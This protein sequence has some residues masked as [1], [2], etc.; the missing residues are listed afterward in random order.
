[1]IKRDQTVKKPRLKEMAHRKPCDFCKETKKI[2]QNCV[3]PTG[4]SNKKNIV[5]GYKGTLFPLLWGTKFVRLYPGSCIFVNRAVEKETEILHIQQICVSPSQSF[6]HSL[7]PSN[8]PPIQSP[9][10]SHYADCI[11]PEF[12][13][14][15]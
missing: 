14:H 5:S 13:F 12:S 15:S 3:I 7:T 8:H 2:S 9:L 10:Q 4:W 11:Y 6:I 1:M